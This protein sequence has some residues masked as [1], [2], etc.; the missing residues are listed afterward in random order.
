MTFNT[1]QQHTTTTLSNHTTHTT[2]IGPLF[3]NKIKKKK[4]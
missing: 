1:Q 2:T 4:N 3:L